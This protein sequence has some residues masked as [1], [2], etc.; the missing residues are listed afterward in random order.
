[1]KIRD[2]IENLNVGEVTVFDLAKGPESKLTVTLKRDLP[3]EPRQPVRKESPARGHTFFDAAG[4]GAY[5]AKY[6]TADTVVFVDPSEEEMHAVIEETATRGFETLS[7]IPAEHP[8]WIPWQKLIHDGAIEVKSF[9]DFINE[10]R[11]DIVSVTDGEPDGREL[12]LMF[13]QIKASAK[14]E[15]MAGKGKNA[16]NG[17]IV[18]SK[19]QGVEKNEP[20]DLPDSFTIDV[21][22]YVGLGRETF[23]L[24]LSVDV[25]P[26][27]EVTVTVTAAAVEEARVRQFEAMA[28][29]V[30]ASVKEKGG[31]VVM[32][33]PLR[34]EWSYLREVDAK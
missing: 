24:D 23:Q 21:P 32:G 12:A 33:V 15:R 30:R 20:I 27:A 9:A 11:R 2:M 29:I 26:D 5:L 14:I 25:D 18:T 7:M 19:V 17:L 10:H 8:L 16:V 1:M 31:T 22:L 6:G 13:R 28:A 4:L 34:T 3:P